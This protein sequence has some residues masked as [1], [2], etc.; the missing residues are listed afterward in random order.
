MRCAGLFMILPYDRAVL[1]RAN[2]SYT[3]HTTVRYDHYCGDH[4]DVAFL[5][6]ISIPRGRRSGGDMFDYETAV[7]EFIEE[8]GTFFENAYVYCT[9]FV[10]QWCDAGVTYKYAIYV[11]IIEKGG[12]L[13]NVARVPNT[14]CVKLN[15]VEN[16]PHQY[17][18]KLESRRYN[19]EL[20]RRLHIIKLDDYFQ[21]MNDKQLDTYDSSNYLEFFNFVNN[22][23]SLFECSLQ[24]ATK[25]LLLSLRLTSLRW[26]TAT[27]SN[28]VLQTRRELKK[29]VNVV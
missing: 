15:S 16:K 6:K 20:H 13:R 17:D 27:R 19:N 28:V 18:I 26:S 25:F 2:R 24:R 22:V 11:G 14:F 12:G 9:P 5:E 7:R 21:Y 23:K 1:L 4:N 29:I 10:L 3:N 8:T